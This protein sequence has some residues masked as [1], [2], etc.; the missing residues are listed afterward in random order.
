MSGPDPKPLTPATVEPRLLRFTVNGKFF[1][2]MKWSDE[3]TENRRE[4]NY[5]VRAAG[6]KTILC[7]LVD[8]P[9]R[10]DG[11]PDLVSVQSTG[12]TVERAGGIVWDIATTVWEDGSTDDEGVMRLCSPDA[13]KGR[14]EYLRHDLTRMVRE[15]R[16]GT[17]ACHTAACRPPAAPAPDT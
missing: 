5:T 4:I 16:M 17:R 13:F 11:T 6:T 1:Y 10:I 15:Y 8:C 9:L 14:G 3:L 12:D 2:T 7:L